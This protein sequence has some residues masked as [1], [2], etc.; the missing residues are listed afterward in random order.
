MVSAFYFIYLFIYLEMT[1]KQKNDIIVKKKR[2][3]IEDEN[4]QLLSYAIW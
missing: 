1:L 2:P 4:F 3:K